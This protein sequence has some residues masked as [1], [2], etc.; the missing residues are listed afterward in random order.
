MSFNK[1]LFE[2]EFTSKLKAGMDVVYK[3]VGNT[4]GAA[5]KNAI[6][7]SYY[8]RSPIATNDGVTIAR[9]INLQDEAEAMGADLMK[10][11]AERTNQEAG[12]GTTT[13]IVLTHA[14]IEKGLE[15][16]AA[17][18]NPMKL[19]R[20][21][22]DSVDAIIKKLAK[23]SK[24]IETD[25]DLF[26][27]ANISME[28]PEVARLVVDSVKKA[29]ENGTVIVEESNGLTI[30]RE[31][32]QGIQYGKG[33]ISPYMITNG[34][35]M[36]AELND[37]HVLVADK[38]FSLNKDIFN[39]LETLHTKNVKQL[40]VVCDSMQGEVLSTILANR[41][42]NIFYTV[43]VQKPQDPE[44]LHDIAIL[45]GAKVIDS[46]NTSQELLPLHFNYLGKAKKIK[47]TKDSTL[48]VGGHGDKEQIEERVKSIK[49]DI[50]SA[51]GYKK[52]ILKE[53][54]AKLVG[55][56]VVLKVGAP[57]EAEMKYM[58]LK[59]DDAVASTRAAQEEGIVPGG[60]RC[61][62]DFS[63]GKPETEGEEIIFYACGQPIRKIIENAGYE[64][65]D[66]LGNLDN[67][68]VFNVLTGDYEKDPMTS[69]IIDPTKVE[70]C[71]L[72]NAASLAATFLTA[73]CG[74]IELVDNTKGDTM[75]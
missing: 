51:E 66:I 15:K 35:T 75:V 7:R 12:D 70:R 69:G 18:A 30:E 71:A 46:T 53:R 34:E 39:L 27:V 68:E 67:G 58:K 21:M 49:N 20:E 31:D 6:M 11:G 40:F 25:E 37:V 32:I 13:A 44:M 28:N 60:G 55:G 19:R 3:A 72:K 22:N 62:Y 52:E 43:V 2:K 29:G 56:V 10:Q 65:E 38:Q 57:T 9:S 33:Y 1:V 17:G 45:T 41:M 74:I 23:I 8:S 26:N 36:V 47:V 54:L 5:G 50:K 48:I 14:M 64:S 63:L 24:Q 42:K 4:L 59:V 61:L 16:V 73:H